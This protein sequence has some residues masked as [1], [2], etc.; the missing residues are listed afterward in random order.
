[1]QECITEQLRKL[2]ATDQSISP[3]L[4]GPR[5]IPDFKVRMHLLVR[6]LWCVIVLRIVGALTVT[7][8]HCR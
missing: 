5:A 2:F 7:K 8:D 3:H 6:D 4:I 1:M